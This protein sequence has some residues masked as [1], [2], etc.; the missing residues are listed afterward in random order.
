MSGAELLYTAQQ[1]E[2]ALDRL[3]QDIKHRLGAENPL[4]I[5][6]MIGG[7]VVCGQL[8]TRLDFP[9][10]LDYIH[11]TRYRGETTGADLHWLRQP[12][13][14]VAGRT[15]LIVDDILDQGITLLEIMQACRHAGAHSM[16]TAVLVEKQLSRPPPLQHADFTG[17]TVPDRYVFGYGMDYRGYLR[18]CA[19]IYAVAES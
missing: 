8:I 7:L 14:N 10:E 11:A 3:A 4:V 6:P 12:Q 13:Q 9:L 19:G 15:L 1:V 5:C 16:Y 2:A 18:N 17:L